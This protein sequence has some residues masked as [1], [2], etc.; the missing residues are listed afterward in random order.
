MSRDTRTAPVSSSV[1]SPPLQ[2][3]QG[4]DRRQHLPVHG[5][6]EGEGSQPPRGGLKVATQVPLARPS[7]IFR[8]PAGRTLDSEATV[9]QAR[10]VGRRPYRVEEEFDASR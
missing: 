8:E 4:L 2:L 5:R 9:G 10:K 3:P 6:G 1:T 7:A